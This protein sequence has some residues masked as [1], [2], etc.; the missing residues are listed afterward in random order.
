[1]SKPICEKDKL[2]ATLCAVSHTVGGG[3]A[4]HAAGGGAVPLAAGGDAVSLA[5]GMAKVCFW[6]PHAIGS[7]SDVKMTDGMIH[8]H[9]RWIG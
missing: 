1:M 2:R 9:R 6:P 5:V 4:S 3:A 8:K 7:L